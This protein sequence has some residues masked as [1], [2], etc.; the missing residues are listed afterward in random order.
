MFIECRH[1]LPS[2]L[3][4]KSP[5]LRNRPFCYFHSGL[6]RHSADGA[7]DRKEPLLLASLEDPSGV[8]IAIMDVLNAYGHGRID[9]RQAGL[10]LYGLQIATQVATRLNTHENPS[11]VRSITCDND[12][13][14]L[15]EEATACEPPQDCLTCQT[16]ATCNRFEDFECEV[17]ELEQ[18]LAEAE[19]E[20]EADAEEEEETQDEEERD[21]SQTNEPLKKRTRT[22]S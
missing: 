7:S 14:E 4:C 20:I 1:I 10:Y 2:G 9:R 15:A 6:R 3:K 18:R 11:A 16:R 12:G 13:L 5:A 19:E 17:E 8:Q 21:D 22:R